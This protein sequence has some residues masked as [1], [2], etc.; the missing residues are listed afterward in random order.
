MA[1]SLVHE[2]IVPSDLLLAYETLNGIHATSNISA[3]F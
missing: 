2:T 1:K 3:A